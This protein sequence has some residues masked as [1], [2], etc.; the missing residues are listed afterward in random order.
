MSDWQSNWDSWGVDYDTWTDWEDSFDE[1]NNPS[2]PSSHL[3]DDILLY[4][5]ITVSPDSLGI[6]SDL[7]GLDIRHVDAMT[8]INTSL[9][10][11][12]A[13]NGYGD[14][15]MYEPMVNADGEVE[16]KEIGKSVA[17][18][19]DIY[20]QIQ[21]LSYKDS[22]IGVIVRG[23]A[24]LPIWK[25]FDWRAIWGSNKEIYDT[26][27][28]MTNCMK[29]D[30]STHAVIVFN[31]PHLDAA[32]ETG[33]NGVYQ[34]NEPF[35][36][37]LGFARRIDPQG[38][39]EHTRITYSNSA[40][41]PIK[42]GQTGNPEMGTLQELPT[43]ATAADPTSPTP[44]EDPDCW[45]HTIDGVH[46][47]DGIL[48]D[49]PDSLEFESVRGTRV[50]KFVKVEKVYVVG[51]ELDYCR[52]APNDE[53]AA[54]GVDLYNH[55]VIIG[56]NINRTK[57][58]ALQ[59]G[60]NYAIAYEKWGNGWSA[61]IVFAKE[62]RPHD[63]AEYGTS[64][65]YE[66]GEY[67]ASG[68]AFK[69]AT[70]VGAILPIAQN[71]GILVEEIWATVVL[72][73]PSISIYD[74][75]YE[76]VGSA[77]A[78]ASSIAESLTYD[79]TP[80]I[81]REPPAPIIYNGRVLDQSVGVVDA[82][83]LTTQDLD[84]ELDAVMDELD[85]GTGIDLSVPYITSEADLK[86]LSIKVQNYMDRGDSVETTYVCGPSCK[87]ELGDEGV[88]GGII[89]SI[90][91]SYNDS[92][93]YTISVNEGSIMV[94]PL[95]GGGPSGPTFKA[96]EAYNARGTIIGADSSGVNFRVRID[97]YGERDAINMTDSFLRVN[98]VVDCTVHNNPVEA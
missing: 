77:G 43:F 56:M 95:A 84:T 2:V 96:T 90:S 86:N 94:K 18:L 20:Y 19:T 27:R 5:G 14:H 82:N 97:G 66:Y 46:S 64:T 4:F 76:Y 44:D 30:Y 32:Y 6:G 36:K 92:S 7:D 13:R 45:Q 42:V 75:A 47:G 29:D 50:N 58:H 67:G 89:N 52:S 25:P 35:D 3:S 24:P 53:S 16:F 62:A 10:I 37:I 79:I 21:S 57:M 80:I 17:T 41:V 15:G 39:S 72:D 91:Y 88:S 55:R 98:D 9:L 31:D 65:S 54:V 11:A 68:K 23:G 60:R 83:P 22:C 28:M 61:Y 51:K 78:N 33:I 85:N 69:G 81:M 59:E 34:N 12:L 48:I 93:S 38:E 40:I 87:V 73:T 63:P 8:L 26:T 1:A 49:V 71:K 70:G 74:P